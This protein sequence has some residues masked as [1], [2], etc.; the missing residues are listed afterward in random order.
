[1]NDAAIQARYFEQV[2]LADPD[3]LDIARER[4]DLLEG[5]GVVLSETVRA[6]LAAIAER[7]NAVAAINN[8]ATVHQLSSDPVEDAGGGGS[9]GIGQPSPPADPDDFPPCPACDGE[10]ILDAGSTVPASMASWL[11]ELVSSMTVLPAEQPRGQQVWSLKR[12]AWAFGCAKEGSDEEATARE[13]LLR[14]VLALPSAAEG[15]AQ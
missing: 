8:L 7:P 15:A 3:T 9:G 14:I 13:R 2:R 10:G 6:L 11:R 5:A 4:L 12:A 1:M